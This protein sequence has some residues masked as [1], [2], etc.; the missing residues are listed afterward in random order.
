MNLLFIF[1][2]GLPSTVI[3]SQVL[4][5]CKE[6]KKIGVN[7]EIW[8]FAINNEMY[9]NSLKRLNDAKWISTCEVK[10]LRGIRPAYPFSEIVNAF[11]L[12]FYLKKFNCKFSLIHA[13]TD[14]S[15]AVVSYV[16]KNFIWDCRGDV[17]AEFETNYKKDNILSLYKKYKIEKNIKRAKKAKKAIFVSNYLKNKFNFQKESYVIGCLANSD[18]FY[19]DEELR[20][21]TREKLGIKKDEKIFIYS[22]SIN[23]YQMFN[24]V[25]DVLNKFLDFKLIILTPDIE[26]AKKYLLNFDE[27]RYFLLQVKFEEVNQYLNAADI[28]IIYR[29]QNPLNMAASPTK[30]AEYAMSG[31]K[32]LCSEGIGDLDILTA[33]IGNKIDENEISKYRYNKNERLKLAMKSKELLDKKNLLNVYKHIYLKEYDVKN[34]F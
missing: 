18:F 15:A 22:G 10:L 11:I 6:L 19:F 26:K 7:C 4:L 3:E 23:Y 25:V 32:I 20:N 33:K 30:F 34:S 14:Y 9:Q 16:T 24:K 17:K 29:E 31:L 1:F 12:K 5:H 21:K 13:R 8:T 2:E 27:S 28:G